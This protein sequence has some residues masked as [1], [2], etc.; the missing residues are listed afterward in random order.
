M[1]FEELLNLIKKDPD[2]EVRAIYYSLEPI[3]KFVPIAIVPCVRCG[4]T[5]SD[6][7]CTN[8]SCECY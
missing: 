6:G 8:E 2:N 5:L 7:V 4:H 1:T 3:S